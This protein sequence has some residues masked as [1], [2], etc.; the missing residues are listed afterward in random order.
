MTKVYF[1]NRDKR[2][3]KIVGLEEVGDLISAYW[4][5]EFK[6]DFFINYRTQ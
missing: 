2:S 1:K 3:K 5:N 6:L 4:H